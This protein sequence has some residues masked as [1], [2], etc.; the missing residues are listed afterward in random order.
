MK[1]T[2]VLELAART[3]LGDPLGTTATAPAVEALRAEPGTVALI[4][5]SLAGDDGAQAALYRAHVD[6]VYRVALWLL[7]DPHE[8]EDIAQEVFVQAFRALGRYDPARA[9]LATWLRA[10]TVNRCRNARR[11]RR[12]VQVSWDAAAEYAALAV[13]PGPD[14]DLRQTLWAALDRLTEKQRTAVVLRYF[15]GLTFAEIAA[16]LNVPPGTV[17]S[18]MADAL[19]ALRHHLEPDGA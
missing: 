2:H 15:E 16:T 13:D 9:S 18:R 7:G 10:I 3:V 6:A 8:A 19:A 11:G 12:P 14:A 17:A 5:R 4:A 1:M